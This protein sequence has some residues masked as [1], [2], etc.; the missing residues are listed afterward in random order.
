MKTKLL[1]SA[2]F[3]LTIFF[4]KAQMDDKFYQPD[5]VMKPLEFSNPSFISLPVENDTITALFLKPQ[6][7]TKKKT[8]FFFH[9]ANG[10]VSTYQY[11]TKPLVD[12]G[13]QVVMIDFR[14]YGKSTGTPTHLNVA[15]DG[16]KMFEF[17]LNKPEIRNTKIYIY[18]ASLGSQ[19]AVHLTRENKDKIS[20]LIIDGG[21]SSFAD[22]ASVHAPQYKAFINQM[23]QNVYAAKEDVKYTEGL[24]KLFIYSQNDTT[25]P[26]SQ[27]QEM[28]KNASE[29]KQLLENK[30]EHIQGLKDEP[31][32]I[33]KA[34]N[35]L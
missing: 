26:F 30:A 18:G 17:L 21:M 33:L 22:I 4:S 31:E 32:E 16:Q 28:F 5:K 23:L 1:F 14:G 24:P 9:G 35:N 7:N 20:G 27:G 2:L 10:N 8:V 11:I 34:I 6:I 12:D 25:I 29:P 3:L 15:A 13:F 19:I